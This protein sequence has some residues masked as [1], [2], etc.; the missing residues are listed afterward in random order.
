[1]GWDPNY[2]QAAASLDRK[3][4]APASKEFFTNQTHLDPILSWQKMAMLEP[5]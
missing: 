4:G 2:P 5:R 3:E 1:M